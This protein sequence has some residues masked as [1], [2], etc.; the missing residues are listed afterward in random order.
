MITGINHYTI[1]SS[2]ITR[3]FFFYKNILGFKPLCKWNNGAYFLAGDLWFCINYDR[4]HQVTSN[5]TTH[6]AFNI[7]QYE[8]KYLEQMIRNNNVKI[9][10]ENI[11]EGSS[12]YFLDPDGHRLEIHVGNW[13][14]RIASKKLN[15]GSW[16]NT[17]FFV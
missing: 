12:L 2:D 11:S 8:F 6:L 14:D 15:P 17:E 5:N 7:N 3:S 10:K 16:I 9:Y 4:N 1:S 13:Q